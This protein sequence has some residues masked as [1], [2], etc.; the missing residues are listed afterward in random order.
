MFQ[1]LQPES[2]GG[3]NMG[4]QLHRPSGR[5]CAGTQAGQHLTVRPIIVGKLT[6]QV[7]D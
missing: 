2:L 5:D 1:P 4:H 7:I 6:P 3:K